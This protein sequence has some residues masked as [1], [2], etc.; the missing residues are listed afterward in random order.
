MIYH[1][2]FLP[3]CPSRY[4]VD[5]EA[6]RTSDINCKAFVISGSHSQYINVEVWTI[7]GLMQFASRYTRERACTYIRTMYVFC[8]AD[9]RC[10]PGRCLGFAACTLHRYFSAVE[11]LAHFI[12]IFP[13]TATGNN[14]EARHAWNLLT[15]DWRSPESCQRWD[16]GIVYSTGGRTPKSFLDT[17]KIRFPIGC[18]RTCSHECNIN[19]I[20]PMACQSV[21][22]MMTSLVWWPIEARPLIK[23]LYT[24]AVYLINVVPYMLRFHQSSQSQSVTYF[25]CISCGHADKQFI[26]QKSTRKQDFAIKKFCGLFLRTP[27]AGGDTPPSTLPRT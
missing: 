6:V 14:T 27:T 23:Y 9:S 12:T 22:C 2:V 5:F 15:A 20:R 26:T 3:I 13:K 1:T 4:P 7:S 25:L 11:A 10:W 16:Q 24:H 8:I 19:Y 18:F 17:L 21:S